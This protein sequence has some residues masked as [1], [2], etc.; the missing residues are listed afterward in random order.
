TLFKDLVVIPFVTVAVCTALA[1]AYCRAPRMGISTLESF[2]M[3]D[4]LMMLA[5]GLLV[6]TLLLTSAFVRTTRLA[7]GCMSARRSTSPIMR[8]PRRPRPVRKPRVPRKRGRGRQ[9]PA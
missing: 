1:H 5:A 7:Y 3:N 8:T 6:L 9:N 4:W 2:E